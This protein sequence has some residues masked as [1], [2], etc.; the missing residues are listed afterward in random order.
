MKDNY[1]CSN[2]KCGYTT[3][4]AD[5]YYKNPPTCPKCGSMLVA[6]K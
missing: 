6:K 1:K 2:Q 5:G 3:H 4:I